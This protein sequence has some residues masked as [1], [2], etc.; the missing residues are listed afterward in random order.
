MLTGPWHHCGLSWSLQVPGVG[1]N[2]VV[3]ETPLHNM[4]AALEQ[5]ECLGYESKELQVEVVVKW[6]ERKYIMR[7]CFILQAVLN[8]C[9]PRH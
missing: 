8:A 7:Q 9:T 2:D 1:F 6:L 3:I 4:C 5:E